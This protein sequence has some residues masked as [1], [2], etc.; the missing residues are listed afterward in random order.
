MSWRLFTGFL[1]TTG[2]ITSG[3]GERER[4]RERE[5]K[6]KGKREREQGPC[7]QSYL[8]CSLTNQIVDKY[9]P[10]QIKPEK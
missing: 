5:R 1:I 6:E 9:R 2:T 4:E 7:N 3:G 10:E 8:K